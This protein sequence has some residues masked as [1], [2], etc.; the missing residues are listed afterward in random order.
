[1]KPDIKDTFKK[2]YEQESDSI[3]RFCFTRISDREQAIDTTSETFTKYWQILKEGQDI[4]N[5]RAYL[6]TVAR[7]LIIDWYRKKKSISFKDMEID[8]D[9]A[10]YDPPDLLNADRLNIGAEG[11]YLIGKILELPGGEVDPVYLRFVEDLTPAEIGEI[12]GISTNAASVRINRGLS[13]LRKMAGFE[14][15]K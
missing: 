2:I 10:M 3:F 13:Q 6:Y 14:N 1:M 8:D 15:Q 11:R 4:L 5:P 7:R 12:L 9:D